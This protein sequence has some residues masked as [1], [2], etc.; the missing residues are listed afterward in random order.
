MWVVCQVQ[1]AKSPAVCTVEAHNSELLGNWVISIGSRFSQ[2]WAKSIYECPPLNYVVLQFG[3]NY[4]LLCQIALRHE[5]FE[6]LL[7]ECSFAVRTQGSIQVRSN[8][9]LATLTPDLVDVQQLPLR[10][11]SRYMRKF[12]QFMHANWFLE[13][14]GRLLHIVTRPS[15]LSYIRSQM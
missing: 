9:N 14:Q 15:Y 1:V 12:M 2:P 5:S 10:A 13:C 3:E 6:Y 7:K 11:Q 4:P 8:T